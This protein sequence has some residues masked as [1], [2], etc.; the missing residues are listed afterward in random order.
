MT[1]PFVVL[2]TGPPGAGK[3]SV[4]TALHDA[5][6]AAGRRN[7][8][9]EVDELERCHPPL[10]RERVLAHV[11]M[12]CASFRAGGYELLIVTATIEHDRDGERLLQAT[13]AGRR[14]VVRLEAKT[15]M[16]ESR[17]RAREPARWSGLEALVVSARRLAGSMTALRDVDLVL[18]TEGDDAETVATRIASVATTRRAATARIA[19]PER[20]SKGEGTVRV[21]TLLGVTAAAALA[22]AA[23]ASAETVHDVDVI[24][25]GLDNPRHVACRGMAM[26]TSRRP[27]EAATRPRRALASTAPR[28]PPARAPPARSRESH[29]TAGITTRSAFSKGWRRSRRPTGAARSART[30]CSSRVATARDERRPDRPKPRH[31]ARG[32]AA[33]PDA[34]RRGARVPALRNAAVRG[35][36][37][38]SRLIADLWRFERDNNADATVGNPLVDSN[39]VD[40]FADRKR[41]VVADAGGNSLLRVSRRGRVRVLSLFPNVPTPNPFGGPPIDMNAVP[42]GVVRGADGAY[43][44]SQLTGFP[45]P[46]GGARIFRVDPRSGEATT[47]ASG[48]T[49]AMDLDFGHDGTLYVLEI[50][51]DSLLGPAREGAIWA[52]PPGGGEPRRIE[53]PAGKLVEPGG[54]AV[55]RHGELYVSNHAREADEGEVLRIE[56]DD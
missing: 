5:L 45:F 54:I 44:V 20:R 23:P 55:G 48:F 46:V 31:P 40:V 26:S 51:H 53:L 6:G 37:G 30:A 24:A 19:S 29:G 12:L 36:H 49:N 47:Y 42:T 17:I 52:I 35:K 15:S 38:G 43:Y 27:A 32:R 9:I 1:A 11:A 21:P 3:S 8:L 10:D 28:A 50:D 18:S 7:A 4:A 25:H 16:L 34:G 33:R 22:V 14:L 39:P 56:L 41:L 2:V 13:G